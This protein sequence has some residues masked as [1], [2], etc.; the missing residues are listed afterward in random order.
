VWVYF[1]ALYSVPLIYVSIFVPVT[2]Y[3]DYYSFIAFLEIL[4]LIPPALF[5]LKIALAI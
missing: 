2:Y 3:F 5:F 4:D 1:W